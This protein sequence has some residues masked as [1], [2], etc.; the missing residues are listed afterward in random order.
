[1]GRRGRKQKHDGLGENIWSPPHMRGG[2]LKELDFKEAFGVNKIEFQAFIDDLFKTAIFAIAAGGAKDARAKIN[3]VFVAWALMHIELGLG[4][5]PDRVFDHQTGGDPEGTLVVAALNESL[6]TTTS[7][8]LATV[9][10][11]FIPAVKEALDRTQRADADLEVAVKRIKEKQAQGNSFLNRV[12]GAVIGVVAGLGAAANDGLT[13]ATGAVIQAET[14]AA[15]A[16]LTAAPFQALVT[17]GAAF[18]GE[19]VGRSLLVVDNAVMGGIGTV[20]AGANAVVEG[21]P[22]AMATVLDAAHGAWQGVGNWMNR[23]PETTNLRGTAAAAETDAAAAAAAKVERDKAAEAAARLLF[24][25]E[26]ASDIEVGRRYNITNAVLVSQAIV[27]RRGTD[28]DLATVDT[29]LREI[30]TKWLA[31]ARTSTEVPFSGWDVKGSIFDINWARVYAYDTALWTKYNMT[32]GH[33]FAF[34]ILS[35]LAKNPRTMALVLLKLGLGALAGVFTVPAL[36]K[37][38]SNIGAQTELEIAK[39]AHT[40]GITAAQ[41]QLALLLSRIPKL[42]EASAAPPSDE[43]AARSRAA[44][45]RAAAERAAAEAEAARS[46]AAADRAAAELIRAQSEAEAARAAAE[47]ARA[48]VA[49]AA[50]AQKEAAE[51]TAAEAK[52]KAEA[53][54]QSEEDAR[55]AQAAAAEQAAQ[56]QA[57]AAEKAAAEKAAQAQAA[58]AEQAATPVPAPAPAPAPANVPAA[59]PVVAPAN[60]PAPAPVVAPA[61]APANVPTP[62]PAPANVPAAAP[63]AA[64]AYTLTDDQEAEAKRSAYDDILDVK[65][66]KDRLTK[67]TNAIEAGSAFK[68][69]KAAR[70]AAALAAKRKKGGR[71]T[72]RRHR[73]SG[74]RRTRRSSSGRR[75]GYSRRRRE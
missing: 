20:M 39:S 70:V 40:V 2:E 49:A 36:R 54:A 24:D 13:L 72:Y 45:D 61:P 55:A 10:E 33:R 42:K 16:S 15:Q 6:R 65:T 30:H 62:A 1:M 21:A 75:R 19:A 14:T 41:Q 25:T 58:A 26:L 56:A 59:A 68:D 53:K 28:T 8:I 51:R 5:A 22:G 43:D 9:P 11:K 67:A 57:A 38:L 4:A 48:A 71:S 7:A 29:I 34:L 32:E 73:A 37:Y 69:L 52:A 44:A 27:P 17:T 3:N 74:P 18:A 64:R 35:I 66:A 31:D 12:F 23:E 50:V 47:A 46:K 60:V 63:V